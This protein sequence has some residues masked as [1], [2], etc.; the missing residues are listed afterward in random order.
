L[1]KINKLLLLES[2][3]ASLKDKNPLTLNACPFALWHQNQQIEA[4]ND[5]PVFSAL[6]SLH[7]ELHQIVDTLLE[8]VSTGLDE[9][10]YDRFNQVQIDF[11][12]ALHSLSHDC[13]EALGGVD[14][15]T[16]LPN[17]RGMRQILDKEQ[18]RVGRNDGE[19]SIAL[20]DIV[21][22]KEVNSIHDHIGGDLV[23]LQLS[24]LLTQSLRNFDIVARYTG[25]KFI[26]CFPETSEDT[27]RDVLQRIIEMLEH[28][29]FDITASASVKL[30]YAYDVVNQFCT[31]S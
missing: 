9:A 14:T 27:A 7:E 17:L 18:N 28:R 16:G 31:P 2:E 26:F 23:L 25:E 20:L 22:F 8:G 13:T 12:E 6:I 21:D 5:D 29:S 19:S 15:L 1:P 24:E 4:L 30:K 3:G 10:T 11:F